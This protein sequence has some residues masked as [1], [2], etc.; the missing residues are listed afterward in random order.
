MQMKRMLCGILAVLLLLCGCGRPERPV[1]RVAMSPDFAP[2]EFVDPSKTGQD[3]FAGFDVSLARYLAEG[4]EMEL[5]IV[6][7]S[8]N[9]CQDALAEGTVDL[10]ISGFSWLPQ[11]AERFNLSDTYHAGDN[12]A[13]QVLLTTRE[14]AGDFA[15]A[16]ALR[17]QKIG[18][19]TASL[20]EW[21]VL[22]QLP[23]AAAVPFEELSE[24]V[25][26]LCSGAF[27]AMAVAEG[28]ADAILR[29]NPGLCKS[30]FCFELTQEL[31][32]YRILLP[33]G[34]DSLTESVNALLQQAESAGYYPQWYA[35]ALEQAGINP[36]LA[37]KTNHEN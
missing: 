11:R 26:L 17:G 22:E 27:C 6:P 5:Q 29:D 1:L 23:D 20:Q 37:E 31:L 25:A 10:A 36:H 7:M 3:R 34:A 14:N 30:G 2:M 18:V 35:Q 15:T 4:L 28:N 21:L 8:F 19:Q 16:E 24:G 33:K 12:E 9:D 13:K 32:D